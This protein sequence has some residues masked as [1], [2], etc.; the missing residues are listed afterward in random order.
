MPNQK[1]SYAYMLLILAPLFWAGNFIMGRIMH[2]HMPPFT[3]AF[4]RW[5]FVIILLLPMNYV[6]LKQYKTEIKNRFISLLMLSLLSIVIYTSFVYLGLHFTTVVSGSLINATIPALIVLSSYFL[7]GE[8]LTARKLIGIALSLLGIAFIITKGNLATL[9]HLHYNGGDFII[10]IA[11]VS[12]A[13]FSVLFKKLIE[14]IPPFLFLLITAIIG[15]LILLPCFLVEHHLG[16][17]MQYN[18]MTFTS[19]LYAALFASVLAFTF[20]NI[21]IREI[22]PSTAG[23]FLNLLPVF[24]SILAIIF[25]GEKVHPYHIVGCSFVF[26]GIYFATKR[27]RNDR[28]VKQ[29]GRS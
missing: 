18:W 20:W 24:G 14:T 7:I 16:F 9:L 1:R 8:S 11:A 17:V 23:Y 26:A 29:T 15:D 5:L 22:G 27:K 6:K 13:L 28:L 10:F 2:G 3:L 21:G 12:W 4:Y 25:L 19:I